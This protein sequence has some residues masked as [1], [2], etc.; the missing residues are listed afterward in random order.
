[1]A[2][3]KLVVPKALLCKAALARQLHHS[4]MAAYYDGCLSPALIHSAFSGFDSFNSRSE[5]AA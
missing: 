5:S 2:G 3:A 4:M 1:V